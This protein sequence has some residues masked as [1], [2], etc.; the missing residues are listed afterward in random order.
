MTWFSCKYVVYSFPYTLFSSIVA[1]HYFTS[2]NHFPLVEVRECACACIKF[3]HADKIHK[4]IM[5]P[6]NSSVKHSKYMTV[7]E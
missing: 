6:K 4:S 7:S 5:T 2:I 1:W 3:A